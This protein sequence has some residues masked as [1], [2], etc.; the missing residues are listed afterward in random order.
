M[1]QSTCTTQGS[2]IRSATSRLTSRPIFSHSSK[3]GFINEHVVIKINY[4]ST[5]TIHLLFYSDMAMVAMRACIHIIGAHEFINLY[6]VLFIV[7]ERPLL[8]IG[9]FAH[10]KVVNSITK[11]CW[12]MFSQWN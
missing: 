3:R 2:L 6:F 12:E 7:L 11:S 8:K 4:C 10:L 9:R 5:L 1:E